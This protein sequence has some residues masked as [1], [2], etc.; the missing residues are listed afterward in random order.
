MPREIARTARTPRDDDDR[1]AVRAF[2]IRYD[3][4][5]SFKPAPLAWSVV[6]SLVIAACSSS[7]PSECSG[8]TTTLTVFVTDD[9][10]DPQVNICDAKVTVTGPGTNTTLQPSAPG[11]N[12]NYVG[13]VT[14]AGTYTI[15]ATASGYLQATTKQIVQTGCSVTLSIDVTMQ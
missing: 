11:S 3:S 5:V 8:T 9:S 4:F 10:V 2:G 7:P 15:A 14:A 12:C 1:D 6:V 13:N